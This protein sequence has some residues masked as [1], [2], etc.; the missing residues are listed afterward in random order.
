MKKAVK[1]PL[2]ASTELLIT[3]TVNMDRLFLFLLNVRQLQV[4]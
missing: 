2:F 3:G 1:I 4:F